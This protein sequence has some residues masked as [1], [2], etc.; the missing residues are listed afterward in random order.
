MD[1]RPLSFGSISVKHYA[2]AIQQVQSGYRIA[3]DKRQLSRPA[4]CD[5]SPGARSGF[6]KVGEQ[7]TADWLQKAAATGRAIVEADKKM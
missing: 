4:P 7:L 1:G 3:C 6:K 2:R 5:T